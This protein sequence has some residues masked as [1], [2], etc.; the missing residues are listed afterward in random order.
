MKYRCVIFDMDGTLANTIDDLTLH[1]NKALE[2]RGFAPV[3]VEEYL[4]MQ[5]R[6]IDALVTNALPTGGADPQLVKELAHR[7]IAIYSE[8]SH[9]LTK[10][11]P[12]IPELLLELKRKK[13]KCAALS[14][15]PDRM[16]NAEIA[17]L[18]PPGTFDQAYGAR[19]DIPAKPDP[20]SL[21]E[22][23]SELEVTPRDTIF[24]G[25]SDTDIKTALAAGCHALGVSWGYG[26]VPALKAAGAQRIINEP[27][28]L[29]ELI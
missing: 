21:W 8:T 13:I 18:F 12:G 28:E 26:N 23:L 27:R 11:Y 25:D 6:E 10:V 9:R 4:K 14:N 24:A 3:P 22:L 1:I 15:K 7:A 16:L 20:A 5:G 2:E 17:F 19:P 29:L